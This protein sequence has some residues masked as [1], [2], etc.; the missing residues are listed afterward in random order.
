MRQS[1]KI[2]F[3]I[4]SVFV[5]FSIFGMQKFF[6]QGKTKDIHVLPKSKSDLAKRRKKHFKKVNI[7]KSVSYDRLMRKFREAETGFN[8]KK[9][10]KYMR[11]FIKKK[12]KKYIPTKTISSS[13]SKKCKKKGRYIPQ[14]EL[15]FSFQSH[16]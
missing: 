8:K 11:G 4:A 5:G 10:E 14:K 13:N 15:T 1:L 9:K 12:K 2:G 6:I 7:K 3:V 16:C